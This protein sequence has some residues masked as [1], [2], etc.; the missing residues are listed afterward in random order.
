MQGHSTGACLQHQ[1]SA[2]RD[3]GEAWQTSPRKTFGSQHERAI[4]EMFCPACQ[5]F[6]VVDSDQPNYTEILLRWREGGP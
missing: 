3:P 1:S 4:E 6:E 5:L 2:G